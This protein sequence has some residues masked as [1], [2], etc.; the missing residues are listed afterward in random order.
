MQAS[1]INFKETLHESVKYQ[2]LRKS[3][4]FKLMLQINATNHNSHF[5]AFFVRTKQSIALSMD[6]ISVS[7]LKHIHC[8][9]NLN[10]FFL[11]SIYDHI[12]LTSD[13]NRLTFLH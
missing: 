3:E 7:S 10:N 6:I 5:L 9:T 8:H 13:G 12:H 4:D 1:M 2:M 11:F